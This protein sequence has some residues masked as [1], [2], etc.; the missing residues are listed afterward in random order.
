MGVQSARF[1]NKRSG[2][3]ETKETIISYKRG[4]I[5]FERKG[6]ECSTVCTTRESGS[7]EQTRSENRENKRQ[8]E[9]TERGQMDGKER[10][11]VR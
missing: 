8:K 1:S 10:D 3:I 9:G 2:A 5:V 6:S 7:C 4:R 11:E